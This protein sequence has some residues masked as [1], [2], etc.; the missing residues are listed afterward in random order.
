MFKPK[1]GDGAP[2]KGAQA[3]QGKATMLKA[4][5]KTGHPRYKSCMQTPF[6]NPNP[7][8]QWY[9]IKNVARV[10]VHGESCMA[11]LDNGMQINTIMPGLSKSI[12]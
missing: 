2:K 7:F 9:G 6:L 11:L 3:P 1:G 4:C 8:N 5:P 10:R 12:H